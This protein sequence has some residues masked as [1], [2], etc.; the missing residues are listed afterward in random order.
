M[1]EACW[2]CQS[3]HIASRWVIIALAIALETPAVSQTAT[4]RELPFENSRVFGLILVRVEANGRPAVLIVDTASNHTIISNQLAD[5]PPR[6]FD[7]AVSTSRG[8]G[9][10]GTGLFTTATL[11]VGPLTWRD[12][13]VLVMNMHE[14]SKSFGQQIDGLLGVDFFC[15]F[16]I[17]TVDLK[18]HKIILVP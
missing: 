2:T 9:L 15:E 7:N 5:V 18:N 13:R 3:L 11:K 10:T 14:V 4:P 6:T 17:V 1:E 16:E 12:H 8:S